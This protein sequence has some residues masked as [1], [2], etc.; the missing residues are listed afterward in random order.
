MSAP[1]TAAPHF[2]QPLLKTPFHERARA[3]S[4]RSTASSPGP[5]IPRSTCSPPSSRNTSRSA[6]PRTLYDLTPMVKYRI[7][8]ADAL[9]VSQPPGHARRRAS[10]SRTASPTA[11]GATMPGHLIDDGTVFRLGEDEYRLCTAERQIDW[12]LDSA[13]GFD[14]ER[15]ARSPSKI[16]ALARAGSDLVR[17]AARRWA[18]PASR[19][20]S[21]S[22]SATFTLRRRPRSSVSRTGFTGDLGYELWMRAGRRGGGLGRAD[23]GRPHARHSRR[24]A[25]RRSTSRASRRASCMPNVDFV[26]AEHTLRI[27]RDRSPLEL[28]LA[29]LVDFG[30]GHFTGRRA[31]LARAAARPAAPAR[32]AR[33]R[34]QQAGAQRA[35]VRGA[36][37]ASARSAASPRPSGRRLASAT[38]RLLWSM[39]RISRPA[40]RC[41]RRSI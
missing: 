38:S 7:A 9:R 37:S 11:C 1:Q 41:G 2:R 23:G 13:I 31:L 18:L 6:T 40:R 24:S 30:K 29:W 25:R 12:L 17:G 10:S 39:R 26:S 32:G 35:A 22:R 4:A 5:A 15:R 33:H 16:A 28:G 19:R 20:S 3:L 21:P 14:V 27:G 36:R 8:G 34:G